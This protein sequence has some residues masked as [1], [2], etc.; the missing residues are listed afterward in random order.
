MTESGVIEGYSMHIRQLQYEA[1][2]NELAIRR[3]K[4]E[5]QT[6]KGQ[7]TRLEYKLKKLKEIEK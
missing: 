6:V 4:I 5:L 2:D 1:R 3:L 7:N